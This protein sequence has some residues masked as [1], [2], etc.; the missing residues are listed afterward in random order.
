MVYDGSKSGLDNAIWAPWFALP[1]VKSMNWT[2]HEKSWC[3]DNNYGECFLNFPL[4]PELQRLCGV[5]LSQLLGDK[6]EK[7][8]GMW[9]RNAMG[10]RTSPYASVQSSI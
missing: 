2:L 10:L 8:Y 9:V 3:G 4:H 7:V 5:D 6:G 1:T